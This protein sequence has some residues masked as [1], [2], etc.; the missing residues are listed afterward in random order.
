MMKKLKTLVCLGV[1]GVF[2]L[3]GCTGGKQSVSH[4]EPVFNDDK[5]ITIAAWYGPDAYDETQLKYIAESGIDTFYLQDG[6]MNPA[7]TRPKIEALGKVGAYAYVYGSPDPARVEYV[8]KYTDLENFKGFTFDEPD[9]QQIDE[10]S[11]YVNIYDQKGA[12]KNFF[13]NLFPSFAEKVGLGF[14]HGPDKF[15]SYL[16]YY[17]DKIASKI[18]TGEKWLSVDRYPLKNNGD[19]RYLDTGWLYDLEATARFGKENGFKTN[20]FMQTMPYGSDHNVTPSY[21]DIRMQLYTVMAFGYDGISEFCY[22]T[23]PIGKEFNEKQLAMIDRK[24]Q[25]TPIYDAAKKANHEIKNFDHVYLS[26]D[27]QGVFTNDAGK[28]ITEKPRKSSNLSFSSMRYAMDIAEIDSVKSVYSSQ[29]T[30]FGYFTD[31]DAREALMLVNYN[32]TSSAQYDAVKISFDTSRYRYCQVYRS[33][34]KQ[35]VE[36]SGGVLELELGIGE[37]V[38]VVPY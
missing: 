2:G 6:G 1:A 30:L 33:G 27:W 10:L 20:F 11:K 19:D 37:G 23:P 36:L 32:E 3:V 15:D 34:S 8:E 31:V 5:S 21:N 35:I 38:F 7:V 22:Q 26:F 24:G 18:Q 12:G 4:T 25:P 28:T 14:G 17:S 29:D 9:K 16:K 13:V